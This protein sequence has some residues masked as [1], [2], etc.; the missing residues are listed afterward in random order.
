MNADLLHHAGTIVNDDTG[1]FRVHI[2]H[3][4]HTL[5]SITAA[6]IVTAI[7]SFALFISKSS[8]F[9][10]F[11]FCGQTDTHIPHPLQISDCINFLSFA[12][13]Y[14]TSYSDMNISINT[15]VPIL[16][17]C[18]L[19]PGSI[20]GSAPFSPVLY[21]LHQYLFQITCQVQKK[22]VSKVRS[23]LLAFARPVK[24]YL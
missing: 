22:S 14:D 20:L 5:L 7:A 2:P 6:P 18:S 15:G 23:A 16:Q 10:S 4:I 1:Q 3:A 24:E 11:I 12:I 21:E 13:I 17:A 8:V 19:F 9:E